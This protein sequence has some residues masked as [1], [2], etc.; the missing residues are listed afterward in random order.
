MSPLWTVELIITTVLLLHFLAWFSVQEFRP[1]QSTSA[2]IAKISHALKV[3]KMQGKEDPV[4]PLYD[5]IK[6]VGAYLTYRKDVATYLL[7]KAKAEK[8]LKAIPKIMWTQNSMNSTRMP[9]LS[10]NVGGGVGCLSMQW[11]ETAPWRVGHRSLGS[12][13]GTSW[14]AFWQHWLHNI[15]FKFSLRREGPHILWAFKMFIRIS[16]RCNWSLAHP[17]KRLTF[18]TTMGY[19]RAH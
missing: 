6:K 17:T 4:V 3:F 1:L 8:K 5:D 16:H 9:N 7:E 2:M 10:K 18:A 14:S 11:W 12:T 15:E 19:R 13:W